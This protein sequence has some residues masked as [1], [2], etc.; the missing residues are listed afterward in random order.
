MGISELIHVP[1]DFKTQFPW[2]VE[3]KFFDKLDSTQARV[4]QWLPKEAN[5]AVLVIGESQTKGMGRQGR[6]WVSPPGGIWFTLALPIRGLTPVQLGAFSVV[7]ALEVTNSLKEIYNL[8]AK[9]KWPN[10]IQYN[11]KKVG[12]ILLNTITKFKQSWLLIGVGINVNNDIPGDLSDSA[13]SI[14]IIR[15]QFQGRTRLI[16][17]V[18]GHIWNS[19]TDFG[20]TGFGPY[21]NL[22]E[23][24]LSGVGKTIKIL[25]GKK[26]TSGTLMG[27]DLQGGLLLKSNA[28]TKTINAGEIVG[29]L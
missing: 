5:G 23:S 20:N 28:Q 22:V 14:K 10:D 1:E 26:A 25:M 3:A 29:I 7:A 6:F 2:L 16:E 18:L 27:L 11:G 13:T 9:I 21:K 17:A 4:V 8:E 15:G 19:W 12:G 24:K